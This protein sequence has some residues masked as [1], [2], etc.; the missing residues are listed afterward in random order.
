MRVMYW[1][2]TA[3]AGTIGAGGAL[4]PGGAFSNLK[5]ASIGARVNALLPDVVCLDEMTMKVVDVATGTQWAQQANMKDYTCAGVVLNPGSHLN[6]AVFIRAGVSVT[7]IA[8]GIPGLAWDK[9]DT[10]RN[11]VRA[12]FTD[13]K[14]ARTLSVWFLHAN[15]SGS[16]GAAA[17]QKCGAFVANGKSNDVFIGDFNYSSAATSGT[18]AIT[19]PKIGAYKF[20]QWSRLGSNEGGALIQIGAG[21]FA[22]PGGMI[23]FALSFGGSQPTT[24]PNPIDSIADLNEDGIKGLMN[25]F[26]HFPI[27]YN[28]I[29]T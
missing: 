28:V 18:T 17:Y 25:D 8:D 29:C 11:L 12:Q 20:S 13:K 6:T 4:V 22:K 14:T 9:E 10:K 26:D 16:G 7:V 5:A 2:C 23:D 1:N 19:F 3:P 27:L 15:A 21:I 24:V